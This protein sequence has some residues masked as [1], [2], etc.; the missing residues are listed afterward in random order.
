MIADRTYHRL[1]HVDWI[2]ADV[3]GDGVPEY[4]PQNDRPGASEPKSVYSLFTEPQSAPQGPTKPGF[5]VGGSI[6]SEWGSVP[7]SY[8]APSSQPPDPRRSTASIF[9]FTW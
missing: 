2:R 7:D 6:Y 5:Y 8:K 1:L 9:R 4:I 3:N